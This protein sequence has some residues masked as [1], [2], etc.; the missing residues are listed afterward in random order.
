MKEK[1]KCAIC[2]TEYWCKTTAKKQ[3][4]G[5]KCSWEFRHSYYARNKLK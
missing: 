2:R 1:R 4:C 5:R 3:T